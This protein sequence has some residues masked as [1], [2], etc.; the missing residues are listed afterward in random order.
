M[1]ADLD[2]AYAGARVLVA[3]GL[4]FVGSAL[5]ER[6]V[7]LG[8]EVAIVDSGLAEG[9]ANPANVA[10]F[11][12]RVRIEIARPARGSP[13][14]AARRGLPLCLQSRRAHEPPGLGRGPGGRPRRQL[15]RRR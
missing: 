4:G 3:G 6:L 7:G 12:D 9:G 11:R 14:R 2:R 5:A 1:T 13:R 15:P 8:A 10:P